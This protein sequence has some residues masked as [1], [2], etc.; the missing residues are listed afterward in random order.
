MI[1]ISFLIYSPDELIRSLSGL[2]YI[3]IFS[4]LYLAIVSTLFGY[5]VWN[6]LI[7]KYPL[8]KISPISLL[9]PVFGL[10]VSGIVLSEELSILQW[11]GVVVILAGLIVANLRTS[12]GKPL[13]IESESICKQKTIRT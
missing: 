4:V 11:L 6:S 9:V 8:S 7:S 10:L 1:G 13:D 12:M 5:G 2:N 3:S